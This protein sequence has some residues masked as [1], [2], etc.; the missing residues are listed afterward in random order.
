MAKKPTTIPK[1][2]DVIRRRRMNLLVSQSYLS[3]LLRCILLAA[4]IFV[5]LNHVFLIT[6]MKGNGMYP[7]LEDGDLILAYRL[8]KEYTKNDVVVYQAEGQLQLGRILGRGGDVISMDDSGS[9]RVN[10]TTQGGEILYPTYP[11]EGAEYP[12]VVPEGHFYLMGDYRT[13]TKDSRDFGPI[14]EDALQGKVITLLRR[15]GI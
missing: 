1:P 5:M 6:Q 7:A 2:G 15:R 11:R 10:G 9:L 4:V 8:Q 3:L 13:Q 12:Y 14:P